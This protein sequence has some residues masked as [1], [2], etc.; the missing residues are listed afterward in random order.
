MGQRSPAPRL[1]RLPNPQQRSLQSS[2]RKV[3]VSKLIKL[4]TSPNEGVDF[5]RTTLPQ[6]IARTK[7]TQ[8]LLSSLPQARRESL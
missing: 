7:T 3:I 6:K 5:Q 4:S 1:S 8:S 2:L